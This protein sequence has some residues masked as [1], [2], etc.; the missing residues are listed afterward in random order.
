[1]VLLIIVS[2]VITN[3]NQSP[4]NAHCSS[5]ESFSCPFYFTHHLHLEAVSRHVFFDLHFTTLQQA[6]SAFLLPHWHWRLDTS[7][8]LKHSMDF[9]WL[10]V[11]TFIHWSVP[12]GSRSHHHRSCLISPENAD[13]CLH[14]VRSTQQLRPRCNH[15]A[16]KRYIVN[17][18]LHISQY[19]STKTRMFNY[20]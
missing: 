11:Q 1:M 8:D 12:V 17:I 15:L 13:A 16:L 9:G 14:H 5:F 6:L 19:Y 20:K 18:S 2:I 7:F 4:I 10:G 3:K